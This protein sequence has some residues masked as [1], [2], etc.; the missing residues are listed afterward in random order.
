MSSCHPKIIGL[1]LLLLVAYSS[2][3]STDHRRMRQRLTQGDIQNTKSIGTHKANFTAES[4]L[5]EYGDSIYVCGD[6]DGAPVVI[7]KYKLVF[8]TVAKVGCTVWKQLFR[9]IMG[10]NDWKEENWDT[11]IPWNPE[12]NGLKYLYDFNRET[13]SKMMTDPVW[14][15][16]IFVRDPK[17]RFVSAYFDKVVNH[18]TY[19]QSKC[20]AYTGD[21][22]T[23]ARESIGGFLEVARFCE[24]AHWKPLTRRIDED[25]YWPYIN[26]VGNMNTVESDSKA[27]LRKIGAWD[28]YGA[29]GWGDKRQDGIFESVTEVLHATHSKEKL[30]ITL[31][32]EVEKELD[33]FYADDYNNSV[34][35]LT[36]YQIFTD[37]GKRI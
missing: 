25:K 26:F 14:T 35:N 34:L 23:K 19:L 22:V 3:Q 31:N 15:R 16:A 18:D 24:D 28:E 8:F 7:E 30:K 4:H 11:L 37:D 36:H 5:V 6:W 29:S 13:A 1:L 27:L 20:C 9:R 21:C 17:E 12:L 10:H 33:D 32:P 2:Q